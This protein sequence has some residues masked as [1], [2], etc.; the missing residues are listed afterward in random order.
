VYPTIAKAR[1]TLDHH[2]ITTPAQLDDYHD[3]DL[4]TLVGGQPMDLSGEFIPITRTPSSS[5]PRLSKIH[6]RHTGG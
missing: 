1:R 3:N 5:P 2:Y 6:V 4:H